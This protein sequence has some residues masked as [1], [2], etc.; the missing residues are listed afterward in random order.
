MEH[1][2]KTIG[3]SKIMLYRFDPRFYERT[4]KAPMITTAH[5]EGAW[6]RVGHPPMYIKDPS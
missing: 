5:W 3:D 4:F 2:K 1:Q 6:E